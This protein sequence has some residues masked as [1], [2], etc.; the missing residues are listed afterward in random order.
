MDH[1]RPSTSRRGD[2]CLLENI[3]LARPLNP[4]YDPAMTTE[5]GTWTF[6]HAVRTAIGEQFFIVDADNSNHE[7]RWIGPIP[8]V[9]F[10]EE[11]TQR[12]KSPQEV[13]DLVMLAW[14]PSTYR[15]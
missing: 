12:G 4:W 8:E 13:E 3:Q 1:E 5:T 14:K 7:G 6:V 11:M 15:K 2:A 9:Q 10:R